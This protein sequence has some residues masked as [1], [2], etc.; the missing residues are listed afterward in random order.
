MGDQK[1][2]K[3]ADFGYAKV[4]QSNDLTLTFCGSPLYMAPELHARQSYSAKA[5]LWSVGIILYQLSV[6][7]NP[8][9]ATTLEQLTWMLTTQEISFPSKPALS[10][11]LKDL[12][13]RLLQ[14]N[15]FKRISWEEFFVHPWFGEPIGLP[16]S[17]AYVPLFL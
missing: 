4:L 10:P 12:I 7:D 8:F 5:D 1:V 3:I 14:K 13:V 15:P 16:E 9:K 17:M 6:G 11:P 2:L